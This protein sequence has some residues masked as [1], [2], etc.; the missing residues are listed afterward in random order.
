MNSAQFFAMFPCRWIHLYFKVLNLELELL[1]LKSGFE[2]IKN[3]TLFLAQTS[4]PRIAK[5]MDLKKI[6]MAFSD[7]FIKFTNKS[8]VKP[9]SSTTPAIHSEPRE[10]RN[11]LAIFKSHRASQ[12][13]KYII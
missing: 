3:G 13:R 8:S 1:W 12:Y 7:P 10:K 4:P 9:F 6:L 5:R 11:K 2:M